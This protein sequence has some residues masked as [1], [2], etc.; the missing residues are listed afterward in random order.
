MIRKTKKSDLDAI[1]KLYKKVATV[2]DGIARTKKEITSEFVSNFLQQSIKNG[3]G[4]VAINPN[5]SKQIIA[6]IHSYKIGPKC[7][8]KTLGNL[9]VVVDPDFHG[10]G[11]G[12]AIFTKLLAE[13]KRKNIARVE[14]SV[15]ESNKKALEIYKKLGFKVEGIAPKKIFNSKGELESDALMG[16]INPDY[17]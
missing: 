1:T 4:F 7:F 10:Q 3:I 6:E 11:I 16:W 2:A 12:K 9:T 8:D 13:A 15:R 17:K 14:L 5:N